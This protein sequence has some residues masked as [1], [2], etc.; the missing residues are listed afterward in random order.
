MKRRLSVGLAVVVLALAGAGSAF[1]FDCIRVSSS[2]QGLQAVDGEVRQLAAVRSQQRRGA[3]ASLAGI[4]IDVTERAGSVRK[5]RLRQVGTAALLRARHRPRRGGEPSCGGGRRARAQQPQHFGARQRQGHRPPRRESGIFPALE[6]AAEAC[7]IPVEEERH[8]Q[9]AL[10]LERI[11][12]AVPCRRIA[13]GHRLRAATSRRRRRRRSS[14]S[15]PGRRRPTRTHAATRIRSRRSAP[16]PCSRSPRRHGRACRASS[17]AAWRRPRWRRRP[18]RAR[19]GPWSGSRPR[20][21]GHAEADVERERGPG[22][23]RARARERQ[24][25]VDDHQREHLV[26]ARRTGRRER[27]FGLSS[28]STAARSRSGDGSCSTRR[29]SW[30]SGGASPWSQ[31]GIVSLK[32]RARR[33]GRAVPRTRRSRGSRCGRRRRSRSAG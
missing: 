24:V 13:A 25:V 14:A 12:A 21:R 27:P 9:A 8:G 22:R 23:R 28:W 11:A 17:S 16:A 6:E 1:A 4:G 29:Y 32:H 33:R 15:P 5:R 19:P 31:S 10:E 26:V 20:R 18:T 30:R 2:L 7:G 3:T